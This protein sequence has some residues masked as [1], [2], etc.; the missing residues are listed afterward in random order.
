MSKVSTIMNPVRMR[1]LME[2]IDRNLSSQ[3]LS[4]HLSDV[5]QA[6][7]YRHINKLL[8]ADLIEVIEEKKKRSVTE[9]VYGLKSSSAR[10]S[11]EELQNLTPEKHINYFTIFLI[12][13]LKDFQTYISK[14]KKVNLE[15]DGVGYT[16]IPLYLSDEEFKDFI[17]D[18]NTLILPLLKNKPSDIRKRRILSTILIPRE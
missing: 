14:S 1:I 15:K 12:T 6:T 2:L 13:L 5:P 8:E 9:K 18:L 16:Q 10:L 17:I 3:Q 7:M 4:S 11:N